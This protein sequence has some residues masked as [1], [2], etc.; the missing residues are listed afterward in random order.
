MVPCRL[1]TVP[2]LRD[3]HSP[4]AG[5][6]ICPGRRSKSAVVREGPDGLRPQTNGLAGLNTM[7]E[8]VRFG[9][10]MSEQLLR[11][12]DKLVKKRGYT[13][14][15][16]A[17]RDLIRDELVTQEWEEDDS[18]VA[19]TITLIYDHHTPGLS[20][21]LID[22]QHQYHH[23]IISTT[24]VHLDHDYCLEVLIVKGSSRAARQMADCLISIK[25]VIHGKLTITSTGKN[26]K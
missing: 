20:D 18:E 25:G 5:R 1:G 16:E 14:R 17:I 15:S 24:H 8:L 26:L 4:N 10:S 9:V 23:L 12:F 21:L 3:G 22:V 11:R 2:F 13:N 6:G 7:Q 19:G